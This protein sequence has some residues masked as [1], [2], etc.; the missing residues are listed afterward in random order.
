MILK[1]RL[2][3][4]TANSE[5]GRRQLLLWLERQARFLRRTGAQK[6]AKRYTAKLFLDPD[7]TMLSKRGT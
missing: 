7:N 4:H 6:F 2:V 1:A 5:K 3:V